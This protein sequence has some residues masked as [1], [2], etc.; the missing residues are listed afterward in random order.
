MSEKHLTEKQKEKLCDYVG[1]LLVE[2][3]DE[4]DTRSMLR[5]HLA[6]YVKTNKLELDHN[7]LLT[8]LKWSVKV[9]L[10]E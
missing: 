7:Q 1:N 2:A 10:K 9:S 8:N 5:K 6:D 3:L 4:A